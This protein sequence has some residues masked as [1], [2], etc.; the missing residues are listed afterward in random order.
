MNDRSVDTETAELMLRGEAAG[1]PELAALL[2]A[3]SS[4]LAPED[5]KGEEAAVTAFREASRVRQPSARRRSALLSLK[6]ALIGLVLILTGG[7]AVA[8]T[9][10]HL[11][12][13]LGHRH[14]GS[15]RTPAT[16]RTFGTP[17]VPRASA[18]PTPD[19]DGSQTTYPKKSHKKSHHKKPK[20]KKA[21]KNGA[22]GV[23]D[24][25]P[26]PSAGLRVDT[27]PGLVS[28]TG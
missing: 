12:G 21:K 23:T 4:G 18:R 5:P 2:A 13:P 8:A 15:A 1:S 3:A 7:V 11:P 25:V 14:P 28:P 19:R 24:S 6:A 26:V 22:D 10:Q 9:T 16:S 20:P 27:A 17:P